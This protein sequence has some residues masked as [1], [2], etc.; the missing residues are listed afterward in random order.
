[1]SVLSKSNE[2]QKLL[3]RYNELTETED[4]FW[5][6]RA[7][8]MYKLR[9]KKLFRYVH[10]TEDNNLVKAFNT[11]SG[12]ICLPPTTAYYMSDTYKTWVNDLGYNKS[13]MVGYVRRKLHKAS[14]PKYNLKKQSKELIEEALDKALPVSRGGLSTNDYVDWLEETFIK[15]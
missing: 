2:A 13:D 14:L 3:S 12:E 7:E 15:D 5:W 4:M 8:V 11:F 10:G 6:E 9:Y 1:M